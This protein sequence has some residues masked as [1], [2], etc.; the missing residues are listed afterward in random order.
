MRPDRPKGVT[1]W[2]QSLFEAEISTRKW[3]LDP[4]FVFALHNIS[5]Q[6][7]K[8]TTAF[9]DE[10]RRLIQVS[11]PNELVGWVF[12]RVE[13]SDQACTLLWITVRRFHRAG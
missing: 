5:V 11:L 3:D 2:A 8:N 6:P 13:P 10:S 12:F 7:L 4:H 9:L 1:P